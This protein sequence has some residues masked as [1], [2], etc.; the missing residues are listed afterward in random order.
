MLGIQHCCCC[1]PQTY[2]FNLNPC[3]RSNV[4]ESFFT[5]LEVV[6]KEA[7]L[8]ARYR[9]N[10]PSWSYTSSSWISAYGLIVT[11]TASRNVCVKT[12]HFRSWAPLCRLVPSWGTLCAAGP[13][14]TCRCRPA[15]RGTLSWSLWGWPNLAASRGLSPPPTL[16]SS[17]AATSATRAPATDRCS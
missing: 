13:V 2:T 9:L 10:A 16:G 6:N 3:F 14:E 4:N 5:Q 8:S 7:Y 12:H 17:W 1:Y 11:E 15:W